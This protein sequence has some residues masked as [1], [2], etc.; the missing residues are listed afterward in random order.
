MFNLISNEQVI[1]NN[2]ILNSMIIVL[3]ITLAVLLLVVV[4]G[5]NLIVL[6]TAALLSKLNIGK[7]MTGK[8]KFADATQRWGMLRNPEPRKRKLLLELQAEL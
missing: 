8:S 1:I 6:L 3:V 2:L 5:V 4:V 7:A